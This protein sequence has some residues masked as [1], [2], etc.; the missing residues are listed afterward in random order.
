MLV[1]DVADQS[2]NVGEKMTVMLVTSLCWCL[3]DGDRFVMLVT[4]SLCWRLYFQCIKSLWSATS[5]TN[6]N[7][8]G[9]YHLRFYYTLETPLY[10]RISS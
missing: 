5:V 9:F 10:I 1:T 8:T 2:D 4:E 3:Y 6:N 7:V